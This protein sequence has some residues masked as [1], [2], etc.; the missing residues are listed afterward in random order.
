MARG[1]AALEFI[2]TYGWALLS[3]LAV[4]AVISYFAVRQD[5]VLPGQC[6]FSY[7]FVCVEYKAARSGVISLGLQNAGETVQWVNLTIHCNQD[8]SEARSFQAVG[9]ILGQQRMNGSLVRLVC[10]VSGNRFRASA[11]LQ[12]QYADE[13]STHEAT[14]ELRLSVE[15]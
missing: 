15:D 6:Q 10:P 13:S 11:I 8:P 12:Y 3:L 14:G 7:P 4:I 9:L 5:D 2:M 1:Q